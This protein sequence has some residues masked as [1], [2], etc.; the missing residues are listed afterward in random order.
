MKAY[1]LY[2]SGLSY[3]QVGDKL[4]ISK[5]SAYEYAKEIKLTQNKLSS[6][7]IPNGSEPVKNDRS[8]QKTEIKINTIKETIADKFEPKF[9]EFTGD[10]LIKMEF[11]S[12]EFTGKFLELIGKPSKLFTG[13]I[14]GLPK[15]GKSNFAIRFADYLQEYFGNVVYVAAEE[16]ESVTL[17]EK[18]IEIKGSKVMVLE[19]RNK[20]EIKEYLGKR[21]FNFVFI[22]SINNAGIDSEY[23]EVLKNENPNKSFISIVQATK[24]GNFKGDQSLTHNCDFVIKVVD[25]VAYHAGRFQVASEIKIFEEPLYAKNRVEDSIPEL[26]IIAE[27]AIEIEE[28]IQTIEVL[29]TPMDLRGNNIELNSIKEIL[30]KRRRKR[31]KSEAIKRIEEALARANEPKANWGVF[32]LLAGG[33]IAIN[34]LSNKNE[35]GE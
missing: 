24:G 3:K 34:L 10:E 25:G 31:T 30:P 29:P 17:Q 14:W 9:K 23:L 35:E 6:E 12:L 7:P 8:E 1:Q 22:D 32:A 18:F 15:G 4:G 21:D 16:G 2:L 26:P 13:V 33:I 11:E 5:T 28:T 19:S 20:D 27:P